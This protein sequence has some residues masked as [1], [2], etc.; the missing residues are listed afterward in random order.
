MARQLKTTVVQFTKEELWE[1]INNFG[2]AYVAGLPEN[3]LADRVMSKLDAAMERLN[4]RPKGTN[5]DAF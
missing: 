3:A 4:H 5:N 2:Q 1:L